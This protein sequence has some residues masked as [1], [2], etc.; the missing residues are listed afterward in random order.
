VLRRHDPSREDGAALGALLAEIER[1]GPADSPLAPRIDIEAA[2]AA[3]A[4]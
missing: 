1:G 3:L 4:I 2:R